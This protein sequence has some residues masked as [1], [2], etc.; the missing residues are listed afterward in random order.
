MLIKNI[1]IICLTSIFAINASIA[2]KRPDIVW[3][4]NDYKFDS[5]TNIWQYSLILIDDKINIW[6]EGNNIENLDGGDLNKGGALVRTDLKG[7]VL[8]SVERFRGQDE[9]FYFTFFAK[10]PSLRLIG[11]WFWSYFRTGLQEGQV[12]VVLIDE[13]GDYEEKPPEKV[14][15]TVYSYSVGISYVYDSLYVS[16]GSRRFDRTVYQYF[17]DQLIKVY[18][19]D[20]NFVRDIFID[21]AGFDAPINMGYPQTYVYPSDDNTLIGTLYGPGTRKSND[22]VYVCKFDL[23]GNIIWKCKIKQEGYDYMILR[24]VFQLSNLDYFVQGSLTREA[25]K[26]KT[27]RTGIFLARLTKDGQLLWHKEYEFADGHKA[28]GTIKPIRN[29]EFFVFY[30][31]ALVDNGR[32]LSFFM[33]YFD[34]D[35]N[36]YDEYVWNTDPHDNQVVGVEEL[37]NGNLIVLGR[38]GFETFYLAEIR[39][40]IV[41]KVEES[42]MIDNDFYEM[43][44]SPHP[45]NAVLNISIVSTKQNVIA[46]CSICDISGN[47]ILKFTMPQFYSLNTKELSSGI[48][49]INCEINNN[50]KISR[51]TKKIII[52][53]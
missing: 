52:K 51:V 33:T 2:Q 30:R 14:D 22:H 27:K 15:S 12:R 8:S 38:A 9:S 18:D 5:L 40:E 32:K 28:Y 11:K 20:G 46:N 16:V 13:N 26:E 49:F 19:H 48:Y 4:R 10:T 42:V 3:E 34:V 17:Y 53:K 37:P 29:G 35:G 50:N 21:T 25:S 45:G 39:P 44:I 41:T 6:L 43:K 31:R 1:F 47:E 36:K 24:N 7:E 23:S